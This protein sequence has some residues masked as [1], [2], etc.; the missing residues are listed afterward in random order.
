MFYIEKKDDSLIKYNV[1]IDEEKLKELKLKIINEC[2]EI[3]HKSY[4]STDGPKISD[5]LH[6]RNYKETKIGRT[7]PNDT[8]FYSPQDIYHFEYDEYKDTELVKLIDELLKGNLSVISEIKNYKQKQQDILEETKRNQKNREQQIREE[9]IKMHT[10]MATA[11]NEALIKLSRKSHKLAKELNEIQKHK[12]LDN[13]KKLD[14]EFYSQ[15]IDCIN[16]ATISKIKISTIE[17]VNEF[18]TG[19]EKP[20]ISQEIDNKT[21]LKQIKY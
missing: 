5:Y 1:I 14:T 20:S 18:F 12:Q 9:I 15:V 6:I 19:I 17:E 10:E 2:A 16:L 3:V 4:E 11:D 13:S 21:L 8:L 7:E